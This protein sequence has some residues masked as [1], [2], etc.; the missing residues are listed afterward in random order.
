[1]YF[2]SCP[3]NWQDRVTGL[4]ED[5][6][7]VNASGRLKS[8]LFLVCKFILHPTPH[9]SMYCISCSTVPYK[10]CLP[11]NSKVSFV[12]LLYVIVQCGDTYGK[13]KN[14][15]KDI[16]ENWRILVNLPRDKTCIFHGE[17]VNRALRAPAARSLEPGPPQNVTLGGLEMP[18][19]YFIGDR[20][21]VQNMHERKRSVLRN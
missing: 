14:L 12:Q 11:A 18:F 1:M 5:P 15:K 4:Y 9:L 3:F 19:P 20:F 2:V 17:K 7:S 13:Q 8:K 6:I 16:N 10:R 21:K